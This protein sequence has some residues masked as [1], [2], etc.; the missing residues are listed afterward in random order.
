MTVTW[1]AWQI[2]TNTQDT[3]DWIE[4]EKTSRQVWET[5]GKMCSYVFPFQFVYFDI[6][7]VNFVVSEGQKQIAICNG[8]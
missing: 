6:C 5:W 1:D 2:H 8:F 3:E 4:N 7:L